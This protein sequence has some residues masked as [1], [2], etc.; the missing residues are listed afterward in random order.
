MRYAT[1]SILFSS[2]GGWL[3]L[4]ADAPEAGTPGK[5][6]RDPWPPERAARLLHDR[7]A[8]TF[9]LVNVSPHVIRYE[10]PV[11][12]SR[13]LPSGEL[14]F[15][16]P[17]DSPR[18]LPLAPGRRASLGPAN[19]AGGQVAVVVHCPAPAGGTTA[20]LIFSGGV[21]PPPTKPAP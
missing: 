7:D 20:R 10:A 4:S 1:L 6:V 14:L 18:L 3:A 5:P 12:R 15:A 19:P 11:W 2:F 16:A 9:T 13:T 21:A 17:G 8:G